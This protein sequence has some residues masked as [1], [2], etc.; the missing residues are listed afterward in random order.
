MAVQALIQ[1]K[2]KAVIQNRLAA[3]GSPYHPG[4]TKVFAT[5]LNMSSS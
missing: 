2:G 5:Q 3:V 4:K 1:L